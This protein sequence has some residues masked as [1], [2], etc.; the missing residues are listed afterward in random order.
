MICKVI[1]TNT[2]FFKHLT[3]GFALVSPKWCQCS[4]HKNNLRPNYCSSL[5][6]VLSTWVSCN[7]FAICII[8]WFYSFI[9]IWCLK[10]F[11]F[12]LV[13]VSFVLGLFCESYKLFWPCKLWCTWS[14]LFLIS[15]FFLSRGKWGTK[16]RAS[17]SNSHCKLELLS[18]INFYA[19]E[20]TITWLLMLW[21]QSLLLTSFFG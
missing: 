3:F 6:S 15:N 20:E 5:L 16:R 11:L 9:F 13:I 4:P 1:S 7:V 8:S 12:E 19:F 2:W 10:E 18:F 21:V 14:Q 17:G